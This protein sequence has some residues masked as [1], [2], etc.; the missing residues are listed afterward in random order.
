[1]SQ[2]FTVFVDKIEKKLDGR[3]VITASNGGGE[4]P[5]PLIRFELDKGHERVE[6]V[7]IGRSITVALDPIE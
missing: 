4:N 3:V 5:T 2:K 6:S 7:H 1:M